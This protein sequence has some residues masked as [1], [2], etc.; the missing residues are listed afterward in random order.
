VY[1]AAGGSLNDDIVDATH[2]ALQCEMCNARAG[3][4]EFVPEM[5]G[6][7]KLAANGGAT[8]ARRC[9]FPA[10]VTLW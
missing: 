8:G 9:D 10:P 5:V 2:A 4:W 1:P 3:L 6:A 7:T